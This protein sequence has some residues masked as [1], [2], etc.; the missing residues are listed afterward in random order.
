[1]FYIFCILASSHIDYAVLILIAI[2]INY[3]PAHPMEHF[4]MRS[5]QYLA[6][7]FWHELN[8]VRWIFNHYMWFS[9]FFLKHILAAYLLTFFRCLLCFSMLLNPISRVNRQCWDSTDTGACTNFKGHK[10]NTEMPRP[11]MCMGEE[12]GGVHTSFI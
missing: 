5:L 3:L 6:N 12:G 9:F 8:F 4:L 11:D 10:D 7:Y 1:M 2:N